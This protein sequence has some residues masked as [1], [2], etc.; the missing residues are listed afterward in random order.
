VPEVIPLGHG[1]YRVLE[2]TKSSLAY[3]APSGNV[4]WVHID[5][6]VYVI[7]AAMETSAGRARRDVL[8]ALSAPMPATVAA[9]NVEAGQQVVE[10]DLLIMLEAMKMELPIKA[11]RNGRVKAI[12]CR[13]GELVQPGVPLLEFE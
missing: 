7:D 11:P 5:G 13:P 8:G 2:G 10:G 4:T 6:R 3:A 1:R 12:L 9:V